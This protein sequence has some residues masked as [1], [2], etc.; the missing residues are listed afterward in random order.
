MS[1]NFD[2]TQVPQDDHEDG[3]TPLPVGEYEVIATRLEMKPTKN[4]Q[5]ECIHAEYQVVGPTHSGRRLWDFIVFTHSS[6]TAE[7]IGKRKLAD[8]CEAVK[9]SRIT[10]LDEILHL[11]F[12]VKLG[13]EKDTYQGQESLKNVVKGIVK[14]K[15]TPT[16]SKSPVKASS[17]PAAPDTGK[18]IIPDGGDEDDIPF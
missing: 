16:P 1:F 3:F 11:P 12:G 7:K 17:P 10:S 8:I 14:G 18:D 6:E 15:S 9:K 13:V 2:A 5:G 4:G